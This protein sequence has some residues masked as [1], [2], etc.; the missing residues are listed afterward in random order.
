MSLTDKFASQLASFLT[1][2]AADEWNEAASECAAVVNQAARTFRH[3]LIA[4]FT[5]AAHS[6][7]ASFHSSAATGA[8][9]AL[10]PLSLDATRAF[11][12]P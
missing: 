5:S 9:E 3:T 4:G 10:K 2:V 6:D 12:F 11:G 7:A 8:T 1:V